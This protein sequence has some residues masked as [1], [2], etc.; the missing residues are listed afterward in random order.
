VQ[1]AQV[2]GPQLTS[3]ERIRVV[4]DQLM[5]RNRTIDGNFGSGRLEA[6]PQMQ[7][8]NTL[9]WQSVDLVRDEV[10]VSCFTATTG[11]LSLLL[12]PLPG[13]GS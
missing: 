7:R 13:F 11:S 5:D 4:L 6:S 3:T 2:T 12:L 8:L 9:I 1:L 10:P